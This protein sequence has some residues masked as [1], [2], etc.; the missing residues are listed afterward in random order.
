MAA[1]DTVPSTFAMT[2]DEG[3]GHISLADGAVA[4]T[5][6]W[7]RL[8]GLD[9]DVA[10]T[11]RAAEQGTGE[12][13]LDRLKTRRLTFRRAMIETD[14]ARLQAALERCP[15]AAHGFHDVRLWLG[16]D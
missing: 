9:L 15:L 2:R 6:T 12:E 14:P 4:P 5:F 8:S 7:A 11:P 10:T 13:S 1:S 3:P 16:G